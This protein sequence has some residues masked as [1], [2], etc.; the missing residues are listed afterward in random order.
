MFPLK[1][2]R[3]D[4]LGRWMCFRINYEEHK[5]GEGNFNRVENEVRDG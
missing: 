1:I 3:V 5:N 2:C 4:W